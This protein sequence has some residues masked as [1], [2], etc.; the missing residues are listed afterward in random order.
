MSYTSDAEIAIDMVPFEEA[1]Q[2]MQA[3]PPRND[4]YPRAFTEVPLF[5]AIAALFA[6]YFAG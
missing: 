4:H 3:G 2:E 6:L 1:L 5:V